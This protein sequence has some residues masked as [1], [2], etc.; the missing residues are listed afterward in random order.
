V[1]V[2]DD[3]Q[4]VG[5]EPVGLEDDLVVGRGADTV[6]RMRSSKTSGTSSGMSMRTT[7]VSEK[8]GSSARSSP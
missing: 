1:V 6:P 3:G 4:V 2:D 5:G 8:P 7:G